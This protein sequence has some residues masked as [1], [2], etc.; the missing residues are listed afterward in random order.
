M[1]SISDSVTQRNFRWT[2]WKAQYAVKG[3]PFQYYDAGDSYSVWSY[4][5]PEALFT[6]VFKSSPPESALTDYSAEQAALDLADFE[7]NFKSLGNKP[8]EQIDIDGAQLVRVKAAKKGWS[9]WAMPLEFRTSTLGGSLYFKDQ[10]GT[11]FS[12]ASCKVY[13]ESNAEITTEGGLTGCVKTV[14]DIE[15]PFDFEVIGGSVRTHE[16]VTQDARLWIV[17][18]PDIPVAYGG[19]K[20]FASGVNLRFVQP[21]ESLIVDGR[22]TKA[23]TYNATDH[24]GKMRMLIKHPAGYAVSVMIIVEVYKQ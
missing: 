14:L 17:M 2:E 6:Q 1:P 5:G 16:D 3:L 18:A 19:S 11:S 15:P 13:D 4:D 23:I 24:R 7:T 10:N 12:W 22:V 21:T 9:F 8:N 20:E